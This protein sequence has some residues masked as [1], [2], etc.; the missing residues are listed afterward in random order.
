MRLTTQST[1]QL[2]TV[3]GSGYVSEQHADG[4]RGHLPPSEE[5]EFVVDFDDLLKALRAAL[6]IAR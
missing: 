5:R 2:H 1:N 6:G 3:F 4:S